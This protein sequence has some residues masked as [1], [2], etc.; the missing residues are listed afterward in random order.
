MV[1][2]AKRMAAP[3][4]TS[5]NTLYISCERLSGGALPLPIAWSCIVLRIGYVKSRFQAFKSKKA[6]NQP[7]HV[8][9]CVATNK[10]RL[11]NK[12]HHLMLTKSN[13]ATFG[14]SNSL[15]RLFWLFENWKSSKNG[16]KY[17][18]APT[19]GR[20]VV[21]LTTSEFWVRWIQK[22]FQC[23]L[24]LPLAGGATGRKRPASPELL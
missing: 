10:V 13:K 19:N 9:E 16:Q 8:E 1:G 7:K 17:N 15:K 2:P 18:W 23:R 3:R 11:R 21:V 12:L 14:R 6:I 22:S 24:H 5:K 4:H 20:G